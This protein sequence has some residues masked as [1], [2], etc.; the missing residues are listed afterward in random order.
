MPRPYELAG[1]KT[2][3][4]DE[5]G[6]PPP[7]VAGRNVPPPLFDLCLSVESVVSPFQP[8]ALPLHYSIPH[9]SFLIDAPGASCGS[10]LGVRK[11]P[12]FSGN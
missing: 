3:H 5:M 10:L 4:M 8:L 1:W 12:V 7:G 9:S 2:R 11:V 6:D